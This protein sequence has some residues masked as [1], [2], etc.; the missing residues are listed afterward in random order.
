MNF[1]RNIIGEI[2]ESYHDKYSDEV[3][4]EDDTRDEDNNNN[5]DD[6]IYNDDI[7]SQDSVTET[8]ESDSRMHEFI[9]DEYEYT[10]PKGLHSPP[11][12]YL[13]V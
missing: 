2:S 8:D 7:P 6:D 13:V 1:D 9:E 11:F 10:A 4:D 12:T 5:D 3:N